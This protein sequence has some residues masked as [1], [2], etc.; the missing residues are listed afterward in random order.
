MTR[1]VIVYAV[2]LMAFARC[3]LV[4]H[5]MGLVIAVPLPVL[6]L[7]AEGLVVL[8]IGWLICRE[9]FGRRPARVRS[10]A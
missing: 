2:L 4:I 3:C 10:M 6:A 1:L 9:V 8:A 7:A 5:P